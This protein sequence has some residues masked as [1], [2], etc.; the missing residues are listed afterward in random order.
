MSI[1]R[2]SLRPAGH[3][4]VLAAL[5]TSARTLA[6]TLL[7]QDCLLCGALSGP[8]PLC[9]A[10]HADLPLLPA[11][12]C[13]LCAAPT[14]TGERCGR[15]LQQAP[16]F[17]ATVAAWRYAF[18][19][20]RLVQALKYNGRLAL[21]GLFAEALDRALPADFVVD[22]LLPVPLH[23]SKLGERGFNQALE[24]AK[25][26]AA[27]RGWQLAADLAVRQRPTPS[28]TALPWVKRAANVKNA[29]LCPAELSGRRIAVIDD[30]F[31]SGATV[32]EFAR[33]LKLRG[34]A[35]V[36]VLAVA[37]ASKE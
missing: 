17:D 35:H 14:P 13:P 34:A 12:H 16:H 7:P 31:T 6:D 25:P 24:I 30:V 9:A 3:A 10:C 23:P 11:L 37:R 32:N 27:R 19:L 22:L 28:Q 20:D 21:A 4:K 2:K 33:T 36:S 1:W 5:R 8:A 26:L 29:F 18:P 15:C